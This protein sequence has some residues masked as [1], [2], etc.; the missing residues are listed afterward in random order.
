M[1]HWSLNT[2]FPTENKWYAGI[3]LS[4]GTED[5]PK[6][7]ITNWNDY[8]VWTS[9]S[10]VFSKVNGS[11]ILN[12]KVSYCKVSFPNAH[13]LL[14]VYFYIT[15]NT[16]AILHISNTNLAQNTPTKIWRKTK[17]NI[18]RRHKSMYLFLCKYLLL[19]NLKSRRIYLGFLFSLVLIFCSF[20]VVALLFR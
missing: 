3:H 6:S 5:A 18:Q 8:R 2:P 15:N 11:R 16:S 7:A 19:F 9:W 12:T 1:V 10:K 13:F 17:T 14:F 20:V 4:R